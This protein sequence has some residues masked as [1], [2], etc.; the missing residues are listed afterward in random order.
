MIGDDVTE[1]N[2]I[3]QNKIAKKKS[4]MV[5]PLATEWS[6]GYPSDQGIVIFFPKYDIAQ[7]IVWSI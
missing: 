2:F 6:R 5:T 3:F 4:L 1:Y 7:D